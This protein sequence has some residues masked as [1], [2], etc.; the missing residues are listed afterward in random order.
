M[1]NNLPLIKYLMIKLNKNLIR[2]DRIEKKN[3]IK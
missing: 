2:N 3:Q 1:K